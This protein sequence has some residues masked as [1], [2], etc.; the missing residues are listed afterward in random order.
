MDPVVVMAPSVLVHHIVKLSDRRKD[1]VIE[2]MDGLQNSA[3]LS[4][5][6]N[7]SIQ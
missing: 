4:K 6:R 7:V 1:R 3:R 5:S 2:C